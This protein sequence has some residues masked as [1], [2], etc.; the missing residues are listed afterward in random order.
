M[1]T[2]FKLAIIFSL[3]SSSFIFAENQN[4]HE[5]FDVKPGQERE[6]EAAFGEAQKLFPACR[7]MFLI[8]FKI[9]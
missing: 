8:N 6:F 9:A 7:A 3:L 1:K 2:I 5:K 4:F